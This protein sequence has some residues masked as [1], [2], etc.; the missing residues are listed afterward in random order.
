MSGQNL[1]SVEDEAYAFAKAR[2]AMEEAPFDIAARLLSFLQAYPAGRH[3]REAAQS[4]EVLAAQVSS[5]GKRSLLVARL[6]E[7]RDPHLRV[8]RESTWE[9]SESHR[10]LLAL[11][12]AEDVSSED[13]PEAR[14]GES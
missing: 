10:R 9:M 1:P 5:R 13:V 14:R 8:I 3:S 4:V 2:A 7:L 6:R 12:R 11:E